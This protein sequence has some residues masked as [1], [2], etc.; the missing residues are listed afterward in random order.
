MVSLQGLRARAVGVP[1]MAWV[2]LA[3]VAGVAV[4]IWHE[5]ANTRHPDEGWLD[6]EQPAAQLDATPQSADRPRKRPYP[7][8]LAGWSCS[9]VG[10]C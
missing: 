1:P 6:P 10:D 3:G 2:A 8:S 5:W 4:L 9:K 7:A